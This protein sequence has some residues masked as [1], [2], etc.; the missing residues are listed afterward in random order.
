MDKL[1]SINS[2][3]ITL[4]KELVIVANELMTNAEAQ[5]KLDND[6]N[7]IRKVFAAVSDPL[8]I[9]CATLQ[10]VV[11]TADRRLTVST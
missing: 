6:P 9:N 7:N 8:R 10:D 1:A 11:N 3:L 2:R 4:S 5:Y